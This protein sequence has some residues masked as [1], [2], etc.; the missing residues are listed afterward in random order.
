MRIKQTRKT[1]STGS[2]HENRSSSSTS[3]AGRRR[4]PAAAAAWVTTGAE[5]LSPR[6][7]KRSY[8]YVSPK[9]AAPGS[10]SAAVAAATGWF[11]SLWR[12][13]PIYKLS[14]QTY[15][16][17]TYV[18]LPTASWAACTKLDARLFDR[19]RAHSSS[20]GSSSPLLLAARGP[21]SSTAVD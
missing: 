10:S 1:L 14:L 7:P 17:H 11:D 19:A 8:I 18:S 20:T 9:P 15:V 21:N 5:H 4:R 6:F 13:A 12:V 2:A 16:L 3:T